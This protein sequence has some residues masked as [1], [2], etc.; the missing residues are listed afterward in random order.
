MTDF[1]EPFFAFYGD[2]S[3][4]SDRAAG[5]YALDLEV[6]RGKNLIDAADKALKEGGLLERFIWS[7]LPSFMLHSKGKYPHAYHFDGKAEVTRYL[8]GKSK[9]WARSS[10]LNMGFYATNMLNMPK[11]VGVSK[12][13][14]FFSRNTPI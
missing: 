3:N 9:L 4:I 8:K 2:L 13:R 14:M 11:L 10:L 7:T 1:W 5:Q 6:R 12:V